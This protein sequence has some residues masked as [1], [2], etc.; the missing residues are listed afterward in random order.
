MHPPVKPTFPY[1][2]WGFPGCLLYALVNEEECLSKATIA[3]NDFKT[4]NLN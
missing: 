4:E 1:I 2:K 3:I